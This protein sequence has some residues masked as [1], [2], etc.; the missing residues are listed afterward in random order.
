MYVVCVWGGGYAYVSGGQ[1][2]ELDSGKVV[3]CHGAAVKWTWSSVRATSTLHR[4][5]VPQPTTGIKGTALHS[6]VL[7]RL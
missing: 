6:D 2:R 1:E 3:S 4:L 7:V 5:A